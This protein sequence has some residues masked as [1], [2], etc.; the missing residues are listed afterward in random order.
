MM[1]MTAPHI[2]I[3]EDEKTI[4]DTLVF[5]LETEHYSST[6]VTTGQAALNALQSATYDCVVLDIGL[7]DMNGFDVLKSIRQ[8]SDIPVIFLTA[9]SEEIDRILGLEMGADDYVTKPFSPREVLTRIKV[10]FRRSRQTSPAID[11]G[12]FLLNDDE[13]M[14]SLNEQPL[15]LTKAEYL[16]LKSMLSQPKRVFSR[17]QLITAVWDENHPSNER[18]IDTHVKTLRAKIREIDDSK[19]YIHTHRGL[20]YSLQP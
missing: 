2:L 8:F 6:W 16:L 19:T 1:P 12:G 17:A 9:R 14:V 15:P 5:S 10:I 7:P 18:A 3:V 4:A 20:G 11:T 13:A